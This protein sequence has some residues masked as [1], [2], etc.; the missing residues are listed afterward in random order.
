MI[1]LLIFSQGFDIVD[2]HKQQSQSVANSANK[3]ETLSPLLSF[4]DKSQDTR[5]RVF[6]EARQ[7]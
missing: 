5:E 1:P 4:P 6:N 7:D 2:L 3:Q